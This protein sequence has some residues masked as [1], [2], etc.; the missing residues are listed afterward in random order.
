MRRPTVDQHMRRRQRRRN[1]VQGIVLLG[2]MVAA[3]AVVGGSARSRAGLPADPSL[4]GKSPMTNAFAVGVG[5]TPRWSGGLT[6]PLLLTV[7]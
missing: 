5:T 2:G 7:T 4:R 6:L 3:V 1:I